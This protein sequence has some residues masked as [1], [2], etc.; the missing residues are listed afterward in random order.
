MK[1]ECKTYIEFN[2]GRALSENEIKAINRHM[3]K[4]N[5]SRICAWYEDWNDFCSDWCD[6]IGYSK[7]EARKKLHN[8]S[9]EFQTIK[10]L[11]ILRYSI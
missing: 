1:P 3:K 4:Y 8:G 9:G 6:E 5:V 7:S 10:C 11:G 2:I